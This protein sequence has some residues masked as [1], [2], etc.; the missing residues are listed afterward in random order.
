MP[1]TLHL[2]DA[3]ADG[4]F[5]GNPAGVVLLE[6]DRDAAWMQQ[7]ASEM[8]QAETA[9]LRRRDDGFSL[10]W[11]TPVAEVDLCGHATLASAHF[12]FEEGAL[13]RHEEARFLTRSGLL[14]ARATPDGTITMNF[15]AIVSQPVAPPSDAEP[16][17]GVR[18]ESCLRGTD[19]LLFVLAEAET[20]RRLDPDLASI[21]RWPARGAIVT[22]PSDREGVDFIS[23]FFAPALGVPEDPVTGS[24]HCALAW[25]WAQ[26]L[27]RSALVGYQ[28]SR[29]GGTVRCR[30]E[31]DRVALTGRAIT[32][33]RGLLLH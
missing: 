28:A 11:F 7:V 19:D 16:A 13:A 29:R 18:I 1:L 30:V 5:S 2:I 15:P 4:P 31:G 3:F 9:F 8:N 17:L 12:L 22:A 10:R 32:V 21:A 25:Y 6:H 27:A 23:R 33:M 20:V 14:T 24:A 26:R